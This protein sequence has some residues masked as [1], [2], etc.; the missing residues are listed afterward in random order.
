MITYD[1]GKLYEYSQMETWWWKGPERF[2]LPSFSEAGLTTCFV[3]TRE[4]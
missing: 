1:F 4:F 2:M 3:A